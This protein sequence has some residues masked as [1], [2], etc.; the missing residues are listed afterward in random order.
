MTR[1]RTCAALQEALGVAG[2]GEW[3]GRLESV[4]SRVS[5][6]TYFLEEVMFRLRTVGPVHIH[7]AEENRVV[8]VERAACIRA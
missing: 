7:Q 3:L 6:C 4:Y 5:V 2:S 1:L 8:K